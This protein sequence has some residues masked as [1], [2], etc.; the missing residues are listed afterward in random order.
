[1]GHKFSV[2]DKEIREA[3]CHHHVELLPETASLCESLLVA[4][5]N[6]RV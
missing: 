5:S 2:P 4:F 1:M 6:K 3:F